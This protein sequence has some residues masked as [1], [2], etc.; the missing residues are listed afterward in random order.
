MSNDTIL[1]IG[2][3][4][5]GKSTSIK[6][7][8]PR[9]TFIINVLGKSLPFKGYKNSYTSLNKDTNPEGNYFATT[10][11]RLISKLIDLVNKKEQIK[12]LIIDDFQYLMCSEFMEN[13][14]NK[15]FDKFSMMA[16]NVWDLIKKLGE[17]R[18]DLT[19]F[20][21]SHSNEDNGKSRFKTIGKMLDEKVVVEGLF[22]IVFHTYVSEGKYRFITQNDGFHTAKSPMG[23]FESTYIDNDLKQVIEKVKEYYQ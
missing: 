4:G 2:E 17:C 7:L 3:S 13:A 16:K 8:D 19:C 6:N 15:G 10:D 11:Y 18:D 14:M 23:M 9:E 21:I 22:T 1:I 12:T 5:T 20:V